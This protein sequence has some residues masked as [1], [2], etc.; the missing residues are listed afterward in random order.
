MISF[1]Y[2][3]WMKNDQL[4][5]NVEVSVIV[6]FFMAKVIRV[7]WTNCWENS[8]WFC[9]SRMA[10]SGS[11]LNLFDNLPD[12]ISSG[13]ILVKFSCRSE[14][15]ALLRLHDNATISNIESMWRT[16]TITEYLS[17]NV[18]RQ[19]ASTAFLHVFAETSIYR[20]KDKDKIW[21]FLFIV[22]YRKC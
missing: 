13:K 2:S 17:E 10:L 18:P 11:Q 16:I 14:N 21:N 1:F 3:I 8:T 20:F 15:K 12:V 9:L 22:N 7:E 4:S 19:V 6:C 5:Q